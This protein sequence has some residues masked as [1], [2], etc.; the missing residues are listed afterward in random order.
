MRINLSALRAS[1]A[2]ASRVPRPYGRGY[3]LPALRAYS[4]TRTMSAAA[5]LPSKLDESFIE[6]RGDSRGIAMSS[7]RRPDDFLEPL[8]GFVRR[9]AS[10]ERQVFPIGFQNSV[11]IEAMVFELAAHTGN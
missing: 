9:K 6:R 11:G 7:T 3:I 8:C 4:F 10:P 2:F 1:V 5:L